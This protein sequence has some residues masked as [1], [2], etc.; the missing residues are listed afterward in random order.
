MAG[1]KLRRRGHDD[2]QKPERRSDDLMSNRSSSL[3]GSDPD[4]EMPITKT[5]DRPWGDVASHFKK[6]VHDARAY[7]LRR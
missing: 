2:V 5:R 7:F 3:P 6:D 1:S 4:A